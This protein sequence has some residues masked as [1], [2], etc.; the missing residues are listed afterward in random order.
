MTSQTPTRDFI[1]AFG[2]ALFSQKKVIV[3]ENVLHSVQSRILEVKP[4]TLHNEGQ[5]KRSYDDFWINSSA[6]TSHPG[7]RLWQQETTDGIQ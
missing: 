5:T 3:G 1:H 6:S 4:L 7:A 2:I